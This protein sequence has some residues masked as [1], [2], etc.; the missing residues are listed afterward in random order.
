MALSQKEIDS[1]FARIIS[2]AIKLT[3]LPKNLYNDITSNLQKGLFRGFGSTLAQ[4]DIEAP[5]FEVLKALNKNIFVFSAAKTFQQV[6]DMQNFIFDKEG[7]KRSFSQ[8]KKDADVIFT[9]YNKEWLRTEFD[10]TISQARSAAR[11]ADIQEDKETLTMLQY[12]TAGDERV[13]DEHL[14][15]EG[16]VRPVDDPFWDGHMPPNG[17][18]CRCIVTQH[19]TGSKRTTNLKTHLQ[20]VQKKF[21]KIK[22][23]KNKDNLFEMNAG[24]DQFIFDETGVGMH[25]Y[26]KVSDRFKV[27]KSNNFNLPLP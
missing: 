4:L 9:K 1:I 5:A 17:F 27:L 21:P 12:Q 14:A 26:L 24:K 2:G 16:I 15:W 20:K 19:E 6:K 7:F 13:R 10:T 23:L 18:N 25:P 22:T 3:K 8:F 11:W